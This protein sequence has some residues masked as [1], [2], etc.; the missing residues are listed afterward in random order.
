M[1]YEHKLPQHIT[2][3]NAL[4]VSFDIGEHLNIPGTN[5]KQNKLIKRSNTGFCTKRSCFKPLVF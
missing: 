5:T 1:C 3:I 2:F 4:N